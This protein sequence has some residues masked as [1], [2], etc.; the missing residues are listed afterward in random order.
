ME[1]VKTPGASTATLFSG[2]APPPPNP[3]PRPVREPRV[4]AEMP[5]IAPMPPAPKT[6]TIEV[7]SGDKRTESIVHSTEVKP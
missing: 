6:V 1:I 5:Y 3:A 4:V 2:G 7:F